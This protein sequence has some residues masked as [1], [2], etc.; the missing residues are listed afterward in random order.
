MAI[1]VLSPGI[2]TSVQ[3]GG[4]NGYQ[5]FGVSPSGPMDTHAFRTANILVGNE[6]DEAERGSEETGGESGEIND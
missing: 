1:V 6:P 4:R 2:L 3:D 5:Q